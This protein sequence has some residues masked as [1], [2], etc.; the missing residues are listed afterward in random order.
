LECLGVS[1]SGYHSWLNKPPSERSKQ[2]KA[3]AEKI[4]EIHK[5][6]RETYGYPRIHAELK[7]AGETCGKNRVY[8]LMQENGIQAHI[9]RKQKRS[10]EA[11]HMEG[12]KANMLN[13]QFYALTPNQRWV[14]D[15][16][17]IPVR[18]GYLHLAA[19]LDLYSR[20]LIGWA[21]DTGMTTQLIKDAL[22]MAL[23]RRGKPGKVLVHSDQ[24]SQYRSVDYQ[25]FLEEHGLECSMSRKGNC[26]DNA[27][28]E[29]FFHTLKGELTN[30]Y[31]YKSAEEAK[32]SIFEY[33]EVFYNQKRRHSYLNYK[34]PFEYET[35]MASGK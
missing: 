20:A 14:S 3:L 8:R 15:I 24:G 13:R 6:S 12:F 31:R 34:A 22:T 32:Q 23:W 7:E 30:R 19:V 11:R 2:N 18:G 35:M 17:T 29:S 9:A 16:T 5:Q 4:R 26:H 33:I 1:R 27:V 21:M 25:L 10:R 28:M